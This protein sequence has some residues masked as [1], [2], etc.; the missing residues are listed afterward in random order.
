[1]KV[2][3]NEAR[4]TER[5]KAMAA[6]IN[7]AYAGC[8][9]LVVV[10]LLKGSFMFL[11]DLVKHLNVPCQIEFIRLASY[12]GGMQSTGKIKQ[13]DLSLPSL[14]EADVLIVEDIIDTGLTMKFLLNY[15]NDLHLTKSLKVATLLDKPEARTEESAHIKPDFTGFAIGKQFVVGYG[16]DYDGYYRN[17]PY[18]GVMEQADI[19]AG[20][21]VASAQAQ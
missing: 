6:E 20:K 19:E 14:E 16:L 4:I 17:L 1:M 9:R 5:I 2:L 7:T 13:V 21:P 12:H 11:S 15:L 8:E 18:I 10:G 3:L